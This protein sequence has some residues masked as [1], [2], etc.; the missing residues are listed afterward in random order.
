MIINKLTLTGPDD[1]TDI[2]Y[3]LD[4]FNKYN[5]V[6]FGILFSKA[7]EGLQ[8]Y[9][10]AQWFNKLNASERPE[11][12]KFSAHLCGEYS[13][14]IL[15]K[16]N[17]DFFTKFGD[18]FKRFQL[19]YSFGRNF[20]NIEK[21]FNFVEGKDFDVIIQYN[22]N[23]SKFLDYYIKQ[24]LPSNINILFDSSGGRGRCT[25]IAN[26]QPPFKSYTGYSGGISTDN[27]E[28]ICNQII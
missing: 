6:E 19:N 16:S 8:R 28:N 7:K 10:S 2:G 17:F 27:V 23:N 14:N 11:N 4:I 1:K 20:V 15:E 13:R 24:D 21:M 25:V 12:S 9:P 18:L 5:F 22:K 3:L 26:I